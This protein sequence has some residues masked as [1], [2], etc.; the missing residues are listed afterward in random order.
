MCS[1]NTETLTTLVGQVSR[2]FE[3]IDTNFILINYYF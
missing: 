2:N 1:L 3:Q